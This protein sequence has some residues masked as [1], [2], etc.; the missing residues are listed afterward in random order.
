VSKSVSLFPQTP[1]TRIYSRRRNG[2]SSALYPLHCTAIHH[3]HRSCH[4]TISSSLRPRASSYRLTNMATASFWATLELKTMVFGCL[5]EDKCD[6]DLARCARVHGTWTDSALNA[7]WHG[8]PGTVCG[9]NRTRTMAISLLP[10][11]RRQDYASRIGALD[12]TGSFGPFLHAIFDELT[13]PRL[14]KVVSVE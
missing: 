9:G 11:N 13:F 7:L 4:P 6:S 12:F 10:S 2:A 1:K 8:F 5:R 3:G 14:Y